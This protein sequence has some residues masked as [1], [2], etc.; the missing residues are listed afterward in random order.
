M[1]LFETSE[2]IN[3]VTGE[4]VELKNSPKLSDV[5][6]AGAEIMK[7]YPTANESKKIKL[8]IEK[9]QQQIGGSEEQDDK[10]ASYITK[11]KE[12]MSDE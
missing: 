10:I 2:A 11:L 1:E 6:R 7:R 5:N 4:I 12:V 9:L 3:P 8:E